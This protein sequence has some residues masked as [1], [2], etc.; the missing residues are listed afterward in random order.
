MTKTSTIHSPDDAGL[1]R[2]AADLVRLGGEMDRS[3]AWPAE[4][5]RLCGE[6]G[7][8]E[9]FMPRH[10]G[11][12]EWSELD[13]TRG[14]LQLSAACLTTT[15]VITQRTGACQRIAGCEIEP[16][17][18]RLLPDLVSGK[19][20]ATVGISH[21]TTS[22]RHLGR[23][24]LRAEEV[25]G[26]FMLDGFSPWVT[27]ADHASVIVTGA[28][29]ADGRQIL[30]A[31]PT[32]APG[33]TIPA[34]PELVGI[35]ASHTGEVRLDNVRLEAEWLLAGPVENVMKIGAGANT[36]GLQTSTLAIGLA[37]AAVTYL[38]GEVAKRPDLET[39]AV[40][41]RRDQRKLE[42]TLLELATGNQVCSNEQLRAGANSIALRA[43]RRPWPPRREPDT[44]WVIRPAAGAARRCSFWCGAVRRV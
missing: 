4:Q 16:L 14:Y 30:V 19:S 13:V 9:W 6:A 38:E 33:V 39:P 3:G 15:F 7:V 35:S 20:F 12:Q 11:G 44:S 32:D 34:P 28:E 24:V 17:K 18:E 26:G 23:P 42:A 31:L 22:R 2:L 41:L 37:G 5:L 8:F 29:L 1:A 21:L 40:E 25:E 10:W 36:G 43:A 27:G